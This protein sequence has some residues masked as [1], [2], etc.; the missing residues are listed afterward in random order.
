MGPVMTPCRVFGPPMIFASPTQAA[1]HCALCLHAKIIGS[2]SYLNA[3]YESIARDLADPL[4]LAARPFADLLPELSN[5]YRG[6]KASY[7]IP[8]RCGP[9]AFFIKMAVVR[10]KY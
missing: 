10:S 8:A 2:R 6:N 5:F 9:S 1:L 4:R 7:G 3:K